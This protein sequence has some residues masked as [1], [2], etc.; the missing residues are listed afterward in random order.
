[1]LEM[2]QSVIRVTALLAFSAVFAG[3]WVNDRPGEAMAQGALPEKASVV[4]RQDVDPSPSKPATTVQTKCTTKPAERVTMSIQVGAH[5][6][7]LTIEI[8]D[9]SISPAVLD[10]HLAKLPLGLSPGDYRIV[11]AQG[12]V[13]WLHVRDMNGTSGSTADHQ[14]L[15]TTINDAS[16]RFIRVMG[17]Q[18]GRISKSLR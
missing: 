8:D 1:M 10:A 7:T 12:G 11:D 17:E 14:L 3:L 16:V 18:A 9:L 13:G 15:T 4:E 6:K 2:S 5:H